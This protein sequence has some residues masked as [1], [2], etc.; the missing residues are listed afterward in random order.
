MRIFF[1][2]SKLNFEKA[3]GSVDEIDLMARTLHEFGHTVTVLTVFAQ[4]NS[5]APVPYTVKEERITAVG[6]LGIQSQIFQILKKYQSETDVFYVDGHTY[7]YGAGAYRLSKNSV[8]VMALFNRELTVWPDENVSALFG[9]LQKK[10]VLQKVKKKLRWLVERY[11]G[12][13]LANHLDHFTFTNPFLELAY[14]RFGL[15]TTGRSSIIGDPYDFNKI[16]HTLG[17]TPDAYA[18]RNKTDGVIELFYS[19]RMVAGK[20]FDLLLTAFKLVENKSKF[21]LILGGTGPEENMVKKMIHD[22]ELESYVELPGWV[23]K[24]QLF[25]TLARVDIFVQARWRS[26]MSSMSLTEA[27]AFGLP[28]IV[29]AG[30]GIAWVGGQ[31]SL[32]FTPDDPISLAEQITKLGADSNLRKK[33]SQNCYERLQESDVN[34]RKTLRTVETTMERLVSRK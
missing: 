31:S 27:M 22:L 17:V 15:K 16:Y 21:K 18:K 12:I 6:Q 1:V 3:G 4:Y 20:G 19:S 11:L 25:A 32:T 34:Y 10:T 2:T 26:D 33:L 5:L 24:E 8:P 28:S 13:W 7:L 9:A 30:G 23:T 29:P 14:S